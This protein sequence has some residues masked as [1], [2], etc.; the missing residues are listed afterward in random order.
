MEYKQGFILAT[1]KENEN[2]LYLDVPFTI[3][4]QTTCF[5][6]ICYFDQLD[7]VMLN[8]EVFVVI[9]YGLNE[10]QIV[11]KFKGF[12]GTDWEK[13]DKSKTNKHWSKKRDEACEGYDESDAKSVA[14]PYLNDDERI[15]AFNK[16]V[17]R[18][19]ELSTEAAE[20]TPNE[21]RMQ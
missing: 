14:K 18:V 3:Y 15:K 16:K 17:G 19:K 9:Q 13:V 20:I 4:L 11:H 21:T 6:G 12:L 5:N 2:G 10:E 8:Q 1:V 7:R